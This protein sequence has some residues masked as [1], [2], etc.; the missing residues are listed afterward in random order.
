MK[1]KRF[2]LFTIMTDINGTQSTVNL[3]LKST[4]GLFPKRKE[5]RE[6]LELKEGDKMCI[7]NVFDMS[8]NDFINLNSD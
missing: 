4:T 5:I 1:A 2:F 3:Y 7:L 6:S 8:E